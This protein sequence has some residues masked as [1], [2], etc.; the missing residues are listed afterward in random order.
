MIAGEEID[1]SYGRRGGFLPEE[2]SD[3]QAAIGDGQRGDNHGSDTSPG[4]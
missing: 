4:P 3:G 2:D 1:S